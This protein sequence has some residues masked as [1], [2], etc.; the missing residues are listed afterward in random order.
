MPLFHLQSTLNRK[1]KGTVMNIRHFVLA[2]LIF[3]AGCVITAAL[4]NRPPHLSAKTPEP[5]VAAQTT[6]Q[7]W[8]YRVLTNLGDSKINAAQLNSDLIQL[9]REGFSEVVWSAQSGSGG[10]FHL[11]LLLRR[12]KP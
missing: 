11:T 12:P 6:P 4:S 7:Q 8:E 5:A 1:T 10:K 9:G 3:A 2:I